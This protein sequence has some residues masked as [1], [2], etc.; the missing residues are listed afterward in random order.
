MLYIE[1]P[2]GFQRFSRN[3]SI[4]TRSSINLGKLWVPISPE[5]G[6]LGEPPLLPP[7]EGGT[8]AAPQRSAHSL[9]SVGSYSHAR[10]ASSGRDAMQGRDDRS[11]ESVCTILMDGCSLLR[12]TM[13]TY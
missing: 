1:F 4:M 5:S 12:I 8:A 11:G 6:P 9:G 2:I 10:V 7:Q 3:L 13:I